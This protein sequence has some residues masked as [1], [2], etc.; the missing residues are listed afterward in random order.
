LRCR[1]PNPGHFAIPSKPPPTKK[2]R[3]PGGPQGVQFWSFWYVPTIRQRGMGSGS[4]SSPKLSRRRI[5]IVFTCIYYRPA[6]EE[7]KNGSHH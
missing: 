4:S 5:V 7:V 6:S 3:V 1:L 2:P